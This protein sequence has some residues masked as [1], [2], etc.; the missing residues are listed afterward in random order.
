MGTRGRGTFSLVMLPL[1]RHSCSYKY[2]LSQDPESNP[3][4]TSSVGGGYVGERSFREEDKREK[5]R[6]RK[7]NMEKVREMAKWLKAI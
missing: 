4:V 1:G 3:N 6:E 5:E 2:F 7:K